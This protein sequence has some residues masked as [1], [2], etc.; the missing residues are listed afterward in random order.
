MPAVAAVA[1]EDV[2]EPNVR[3]NGIAAPLY[4]QIAALESGALKVSFET[5]GHA[6]YVLTKLR[7]IA[8]KEGHDLLSSRSADG[9]T[10]YFW[11]QKQ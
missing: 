11:L 2:P 9:K 5:K 7:K 6:S 10:R 1:M 4:A 3:N 8:K